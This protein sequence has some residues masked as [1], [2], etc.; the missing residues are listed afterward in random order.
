M[1]EDQIG[2]LRHVEGHFSYNN[3]EDKKNIRN[4]PETGGGGIPDIGVYTYGATIWATNQDPIE[5]QHADI[6]FEHGVDVVA[7]VSARFE[8][9]TTHWVNSMRMSPFQT[10]RF[11]GE[12]GV[13]ELTAPFNPLI[14]GAAEVIWRDAKGQV[15]KEVFAGAN[16]YVAQVERFGE[17]VLNGQPLSWSLEEAYRTQRV[18]DQVFEIARQARG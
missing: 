11:I 3:A 10:M 5:I 13:I 2:P 6:T 17:C 4:R 9:F 7:N 1:Q 16:H 14:Y 12:R 18:I 8:G 15:S